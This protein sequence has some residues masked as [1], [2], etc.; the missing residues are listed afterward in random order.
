MKNKFTHYICNALLILLGAIIALGIAEGSLRLFKGMPSVVERNSEKYFD[1]Y[2]RYIDIYDKLYVK[3][4]K[5]GFYVCNR[6]RT[7]SFAAKY[8]P[9]KKTA[10]EK[11]V[12]VIGESVAANLSFKE[13]YFLAKLNEAS[14]SS[15]WQ[16]INCGVGGYDSYRIRLVAKEIVNYEPDFVV[17]MMGNNP[18]F[19][20][21]TINSWKYR[22]AI[23]RHSWVLQ[24]VTDVINGPVEISDEQDNKFYEK[25]LAEIINIITSKEIPLVLI[26]LPRNTHIVEYGGFFGGD[27]TAFMQWWLLQLDPLKII[28]EGNKDMLKQAVAYEKLHN[29]KKARRLFREYSDEMFSVGDFKRFRERNQMCRECARK[30]KHLI[31]IDL[32]K[33]I[34][35]AQNNCPGFETFIDSA[36]FWPSVNNIICD[37]IIKQVY[38]KQTPVQANV[39]QDEILTCWEDKLNN[40]GSFGS[41]DLFGAVQLTS[42]MYQRDPRILDIHRYNK[43]FSSTGKEYYINILILGEAFRQAGRFKEAL[44]CYSKA[45]SL[46]KSRFEGYLLRSIFYFQIHDNNKSQEDMNTLHVLEPKFSWLS[47]QLLTSLDLNRT[48]AH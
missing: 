19:R 18:H 39:S 40:Q 38:G 7:F 27:R 46:D 44:Y 13:S 9:I 32:E 11:R 45:I 36:H 15:Q 22:Y 5:L 17:L 47:L 33:I 8:F 26:T 21:L 48:K 37:G 43:L 10:A 35:D 31:L 23:V 24:I 12:F 16:I 20:P 30:N 3:D 25:N 1:L 2:W 42:Y 14:P 4:N 28:Q 6:Q 41:W 34:M 29:L